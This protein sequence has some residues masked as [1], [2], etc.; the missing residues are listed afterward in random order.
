MKR[1]AASLY[2]VA[3]KRTLGGALEQHNEVFLHFRR[4]ALMSDEMKTWRL[5]KG[6]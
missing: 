6:H 5:L 4:C 3:W 2:K 1:K